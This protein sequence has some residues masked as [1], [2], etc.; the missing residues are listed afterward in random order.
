[1]RSRA[2]TS[3]PRGQVQVDRKERG[4]PVVGVNDV[5]AMPAPHPE[6]RPA[7]NVKR[8][9]RR[10]TRRNVP[11]RCAAGE[12]NVVSTRTSGMSVTRA[13]CAGIGLSINSP[14][15]VVV[16]RASSGATSF[17]NHSRA[18]R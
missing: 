9:C 17:S 7:K 15:H 18:C 10:R 6:R 14:T 13:W 2:G 11:V 1:M 12:S 8:S 4:V 16:G 5:G 3:L